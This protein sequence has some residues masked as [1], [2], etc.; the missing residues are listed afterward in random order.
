MIKSKIL[1]VE[2]EPEINEIITTAFQK[3]DYLVKSV[4]SLRD[5][6]TE[7]DTFGYSLVILDV[8]LPDGSGFDFLQEIRSQ[9]PKLPVIILTARIK[10][11]DI[12]QG[13]E[14]GATDYLS[15]PFRSKELIL[16]SR[17]ILARGESAA[18]I[19]T[20]KNCTL[21]TKKK[22]VYVNETIVKLTY[23]EYSLMHL[24]LSNQ[25]KLLSRVDLYSS[26][27]GLIEEPDYHRLEATVSNLRKKMKKYGFNSIK[28][29]AKL[30]YSLE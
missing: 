21:N 18:F 23:K 29:N 4:L 1:V 9:Q 24:L 25:D 16:R 11:D 5:A 22:A 10:S 3:E 13:L 15:K 19:Y 17:N 20:F 14:Y 30:G 7:V 27:W 2:D 6:K 8:N 28:T 26:L 12:E